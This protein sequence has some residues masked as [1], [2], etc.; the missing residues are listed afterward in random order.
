MKYD[1]INAS[2]HCYINELS[3]GYREQRAKII[4]E[5]FTSLLDINM[6]VY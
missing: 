2:L 1:K 5:S 3:N 4:A 6:Q